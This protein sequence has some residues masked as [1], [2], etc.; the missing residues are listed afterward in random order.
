MAG[1][2]FLIGSVLVLFAWAAAMAVLA[3]W[4]RWYGHIEQKRR[5]RIE[6]EWRHLADRLVLEGVPLPP[7]P[8]RQRPIVLELLLRYQRFLRGSE[9]ARITAYLE[10]QGYVRS[11]VRELGARNRWR[12][13]R[14]A[15]LLGRIRSESAVD[16]L[17]ARLHDESEDV[18]TVAAR[19][20]A[21]IG[22]PKAVHALAAALADPSRWTASAVAA[23]LV[24]M[25]PAAVPTLLEIAAGADSEQPGAREAAVMAVRVLGEIRDPRAEPVLISLLKNA[26]LNLRAR[27]A[28]AL[29]SVGGPRTPPALRA[30]LRDPAWQVRAQAA[31]SLGSLG[32]RGSV[33]AL[34]AAIE[35]KSWWVRCNC[36]DALAKLG[37]PGAAALRMLAASHDAYVRHRCLAA[38]ETVELDGQG[39]TPPR[40]AAPPFSAESPA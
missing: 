27:A 10:G 6:A 16:P 18:R 40:P 38:L 7:L 23:D 24:D 19:S 20:L 22:H 1:E 26:D 3:V 32:D 17:V 29:G 37:E 39:V 11:A 31:A 8:R 30:A 36:A 4:L 15:A 9:A 13:A 5:R 35:D 12:R 21:A 33:E 25:G 2:D 34:S 28:A 14:A